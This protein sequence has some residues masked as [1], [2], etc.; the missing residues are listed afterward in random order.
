M[1]Q[2]YNRPVTLHRMTGFWDNGL[3]KAKLEIAPPF[4]K[5]WVQLSVSLDLAG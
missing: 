5:G 4:P 1:C 2:L 3:G